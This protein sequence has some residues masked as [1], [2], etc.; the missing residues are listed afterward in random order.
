[1]AGGHGGVT[2]RRGGG[3]PRNPGADR[4]P[5]HLQDDMAEQPAASGTAP[6]FL[7]E[8]EQPAH[9]EGRPA[10]AVGV[11]HRVPGGAGRNGRPGG[12][13]A[14]GADDHAARERAG[15]VCSL[16]GDAPAH[17][18]LLRHEQ[19]PAHPDGPERQPPLDAF[20]GGVHRQ[21]IQPSGGLCGGVCPGIYL[22]AAGVSLL[23]DGGGDNGTEPS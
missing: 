5:G 9:H 17:C 19:Q 7:S 3:E 23:A 4:P 8:D 14:E 13:P 10:D 21:S 2:A 12:E 1:M 22:A 20:R 15:G 6:L 16:Q 11:C 18:Q